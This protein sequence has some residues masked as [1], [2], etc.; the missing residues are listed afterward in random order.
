MTDI[1]VH[2][3]LDFILLEF[4][5]D[6][7]TDQAAAEM[8]ALV[9]DGL[10]RIWDFLAVRKETDGTFSGIA[11]E[12]STL[13]AFSHFDGAR[14]GLLDDDDVARAAE[15]LSPGTIAVMVLYENAWAIPFVAASRAAG[16]ELVASARIPAAEVIEAL[17]ALEG[18]SD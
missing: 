10:V 12:G 3:P 18:S 13:E 2:G 7:P 4:P 9:E 14:S 16:G 8:L 6:R 15:A 11:L 17:E 5:G 1:D